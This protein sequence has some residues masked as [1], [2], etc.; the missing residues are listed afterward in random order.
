MTVEEHDSKQLNTT[1]KTFGRY[2]AALQ[3][4][5]YRE[6]KT[7]ALEVEGNAANDIAT[8]FI[9]ATDKNHSDEQFA[10]I[11]KAAT[12]ADNTPVIQPQVTVEPP[13]ASPA[14]LA[15]V[16]QNSQ[17]IRLMAPATSCR[18]RFLVGFNL[19]GVAGQ[20]VSFV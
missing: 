6:G 16:A 7:V 8:A 3:G 12:L 19:L 9:H 15:A 2:R 11:W 17:P 20:G 18:Q 13:V 14:P 5:G 10:F 4:T 1:A